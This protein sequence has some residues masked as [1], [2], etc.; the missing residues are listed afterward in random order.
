MNLKTRIKELAAKAEAVTELARGDFAIPALKKILNSS[1]ADR[2]LHEVPGI[3]GALRKDPSKMQRH[4]A[5]LGKRNNYW[6]ERANNPTYVSDYIDGAPVLGN[7][8]QDDLNHLRSYS[9][10]T[11]KQYRKGKWAGPFAD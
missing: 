11:I 7:Q 1:P 8:T 10:K 9:A 4:Y 5:A 3:I 2:R 6:R